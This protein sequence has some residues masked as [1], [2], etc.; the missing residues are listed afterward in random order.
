MHCH[1]NCRAAAYVQCRTADGRV[2]F[3]VGIDTNVA[4]ASVHAVLSAANR[5]G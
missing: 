3:G 4:T 1:R 5:L 2:A